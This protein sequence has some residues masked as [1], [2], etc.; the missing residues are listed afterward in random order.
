MTSDEWS[1]ARPLHSRALVRCMPMSLVRLGVPALE[2]SD[3]PPGVRQR[4][5]VP[6]AFVFHA[7]NRPLE[8]PTDPVVAPDAD[9]L[10]AN[11]HRVAPA[12]RR[13]R[14]NSYLTASCMPMLSNRPTTGTANAHYKRLPYKA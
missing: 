11:A 3:S 2:P 8:A 4:H 12:R 1:A 5:D 14:C 10:E 7:L 9:V 6:R 13:Q